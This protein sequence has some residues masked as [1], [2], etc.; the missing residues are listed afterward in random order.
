MQN[1]ARGSGPDSLNCSRTILLLR[2]HYTKTGQVTALGKVAELEDPFRVLIATV[3]SQRTR[4]EVTSRAERALFGRFGDAKSISRA[5]IGEIE[6]LIRNVGF[7]R[8]KARAIREISREI[9]SRFDGRVPED[10][11]S[12][13]SLP[14]VGRKTANCVLVFG[15]GKPAIPVD[16]HVH[17]ISNRLGWVRTRTPEETETALSKLIPRV[18]WLD[19]NE[20]MVTHGKNV[21]RPLNPRCDI[22][23]I[24]RYCNYQLKRR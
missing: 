19:V 11:E 23:P 15:F 9:L 24:A 7:Y 14:L 12:L 16:T 10:L 2:K 22:C 20:L 18:R 3:L 13:L 1:T 17:R 4:D 6:N 5:G 8:A 21:C